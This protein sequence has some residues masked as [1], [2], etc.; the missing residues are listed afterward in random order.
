[1][2]KIIL[3]LTTFLSFITCLSRADIVDKLTDL[4]KLYK[5]GALNDEEFKKAKKILLKTNAEKNENEKITPIIKVKKTIPNEFDRDL[6]K[7]FLK[8]EELEKIGEYKKI[9]KYPDG[10]F[11]NLN[12]S[13]S[14]LAKKATQEMYKVFVQN[15]N[16]QEKYPENMMRAMAYFEVFFNNKLKEERKAIQDYHENFPSVK[17]SSK[18]SIKS[19]YSL[20]QAK[21][22]MRE[23]VGLT[24]DDNLEQALLRYMHM[25]Q[26]LSQGKKSQNKLSIEEKKLKKESTK[27]KKYYGSF[28][29]NLELKA[30]QRITQ[31]EFNKEINKNIKNIKKILINLNKI[32][33]DKYNIYKTVNEIFAESLKLLESCKDNCERKDLLTVIDSI[34][35]NNSILNIVEKKIIKKKI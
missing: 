2:I 3:I 18:K 29:K 33:P 28:K 20:T 31:K 19:L 15:K 35:L 1:M 6:S 9:I 8:K 12:F 23:S 34:E 17:K 32:N 30:E 26:F 10:L 16:L 14:M 25:Y 11:D 24:L 21:K 13:D 4:N 7:T 5:E 27:F 22:S